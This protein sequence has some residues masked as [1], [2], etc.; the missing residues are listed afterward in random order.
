MPVSSG[1]ANKSVVQIYRISDKTGEL[2]L[3]E[4][5]GTDGHDET[6]GNTLY[7]KLINNE[8]VYITKEEYNSWQQNLMYKKFEVT[9]TIS[10]YMP[11]T[12]LFDQNHPA[13]EPYVP[14]ADG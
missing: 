10:E 14:R 3:L 8:K 5:G 1:Q 4:E 11:C 9:E 2:I 7:Y 6:S 12:P 13:P